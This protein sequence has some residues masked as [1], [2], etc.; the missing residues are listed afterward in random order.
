MNTSTL[1]EIYGNSKEK[2]M[3]VCDEYKKNCS[4]DKNTCHNMFANCS[5]TCLLIDLQHIRDSAQRDDE[6]GEAM[7]HRINHHKHETPIE[8]NI[9]DKDIIQLYY[10]ESVFHYIFIYIVI[11]IFAI[12]TFSASNKTKSN[13]TLN[14]LV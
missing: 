14:F 11:I 9:N 12:L 7:S 3:K 5:N 1:F 8:A 6:R 13:T 2:C 10:R 4:A